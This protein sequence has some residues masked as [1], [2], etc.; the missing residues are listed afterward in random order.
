MSKLLKRER[1]E[2]ENS[3]QISQIA[4]TAV[5]ASKPNVI[6]HSN[7]HAGNGPVDDEFY[8]PNLRVLC[9]DVD[10]YWS[11]YFYV[12]KG[13]VFKFAMIYITHSDDPDN[14][15]NVMSGVIYE[16]DDIH[17]GGQEWDISGAN[18][19]FTLA[20]TGALT[21]AEYGTSFT[22]ADNS[23]VAVKWDKDDNAEGSSGFLCVYG[24]L[25]IRQ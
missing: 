17:E 24:G 11:W 1:L 2:Q 13:G 14:N 5:S 3:E 15:G 10:A 18:C 8:G 19:D 7:M 25:L 22:V 4:A 20:V 9:S 6:A 23:K 16:Q 12:E 21:I